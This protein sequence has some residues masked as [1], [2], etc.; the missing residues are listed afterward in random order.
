MDRVLGG[1]PVADVA[2]GKTQAEYQR[3]ARR[4]NALREA[5]AVNPQLEGPALR[6]LYF[7]PEGRKPSVPENLIKDLKTKATN[8]S[9]KGAGTTNV[10]NQSRSKI[11]FRAGGSK[12][13]G[14]FAALADHVRKEYVEMNYSG[15]HAPGHLTKPLSI[16]TERRVIKQADLKAR[17]A[18]TSTDRR[19]EA[20]GDQYNTISTLAAVTA[21]YNVIPGVDLGAGP[22]SADL[23]LNHDKTTLCLNGEG[24]AEIVTSDEV[25]AEAKRQKTSLNTLADNN[26][27]QQRRTLGLTNITSASG[28]FHGCIAQIK[29]SRFATLKIDLLSVESKLWLATYNTKVDE[30]ELA[31]ALLFTVIFPVADKIRA[32]R[33][34][35][36]SSAPIYPAA[37]PRRPASPAIDTTSTSLATASSSSQTQKPS[38]NKSEPPSLPQQPIA[39]ASLASLESTIKSAET[40]CPSQLILQSPFGEPEN[41]DTP[42]DSLNLKFTGDNQFVINE[43]LKGI[44]ALPSEVQILLGNIKSSY[45]ELLKLV[46]STSKESSQKPNFGRLQGGSEDVE[47]AAIVMDGEHFQLRAFVEDAG[48]Q[49][50]AEHNI[51]GLKVAGGDTATGQPNDQMASHRT[52]KQ[53]MRSPAYKHMGL[54]DIPQPSWRAKL[55]D[56]L[57]PLP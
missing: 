19:I 21:L 8:A 29:D 48:G 20:R 22:L 54:E 9:M 47:R 35:Q 12:P 26:Q 16:S 11:A 3:I 55:D 42:H 27:S 4:A 40:V 31:N 38:P 2:R 5:L 32:E 25:I 53:F 41:F 7:P 52:I 17:G 56:F 14:S 37:P 49:Y 18:D 51:D 1:E 50:T 46:D 33:K 36:S 28:T 34:Q 43:S 57:K 39:A 23:L 30:L 13:T 44:E 10:P 6:A 45:F 24:K 15:G